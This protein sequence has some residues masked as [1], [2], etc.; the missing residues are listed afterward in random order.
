MMS[1][2]DRRSIHGMK[3]M[4]SIVLLS[5]LFFSAPLALAGIEQIY[6]MTR[7]A[8]GAF[9]VHC[10]DQTKE[11]ASVDQIKQNQV[12]LNAPQP[13]GLVC[14]ASGRGYFALTRIAD[15]AK[16]GELL[17][18]KACLALVEN[19][20]AGLVCASTGRGYFSVTRITDGKALGEPLSEKACLPLVK[21]A[22]A[23]LVCTSNGRG[24]FGI[25]RISDGETFGEL[26]S[27]E[28][29][30]ALVQQARSGL[31][32]A[33]NGRGYYGITRIADGEILGDLLSYEKCLS[34]L[35]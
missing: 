7:R 4:T 24:Y 15:G 25:T 5:V 32:C 17:S 23:G 16:L 34:S 35:K 33:S 14:T 30:T 28:I 19:A 20:Q 18:E 10:V 3:L 12:C 31:V 11:I 26:V 27:E 9:D 29:C 6:S 22:Q 8:D 21:N 13:D 1:R 2:H